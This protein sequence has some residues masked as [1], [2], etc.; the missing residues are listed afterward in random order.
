MW[1]R[2]KSD[3]YFPTSNSYKKKK[4]EHLSLGMLNAS[5]FPIMSGT[6]DVQCTPS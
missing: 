2:R 4:D 3:L 5:S 6:S 1:M